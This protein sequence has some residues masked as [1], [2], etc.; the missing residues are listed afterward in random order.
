MNRKTFNLKNKIDTE[1]IISLSDN[2]HY[3]KKEGQNFYYSPSGKMISLAEKLP[4][5]DW[6]IVK[7]WRTTSVLVG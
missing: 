2:Y 3:T 5:G 4:N 7:T 6:W 1:R